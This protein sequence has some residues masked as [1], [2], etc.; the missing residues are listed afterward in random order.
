MDSK[1]YIDIP[2]FE[3]ILTATFVTIYINYFSKRN[4]LP[5]TQEDRL[6]IRSLFELDN[7]LKNA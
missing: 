2:W 6:I 7:Y 1:T 4:I 5:N 3:F